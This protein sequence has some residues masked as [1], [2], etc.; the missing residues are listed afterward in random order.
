MTVATKQ[1]IKVKT[2]R[3]NVLCSNRS[4]DACL[5]RL[6]AEN[7]I[8]LDTNADDKRAKCVQ[9]TD[10]GKESLKQFFDEVLN[11]FKV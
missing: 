1:P 4:F 3:S 6:Q 2:L 10:L 9:L 8:E 7:L 11:K 5:A